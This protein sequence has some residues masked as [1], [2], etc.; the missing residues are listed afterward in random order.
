MT[1]RL[2]DPYQGPGTVGPGA[3]EGCQRWPGQVIPTRDQGLLAPDLRRT[4]RDGQAK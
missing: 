3:K 1:A 4:V 2:S